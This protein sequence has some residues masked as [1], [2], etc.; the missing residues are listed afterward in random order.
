M[1]DAVFGIAAF[2]ATVITIAY[3]L[4]EYQQ[5]REFAFGGTEA[6]CTVSSSNDSRLVMNV[7]ECRSYISAI[8]D[9]NWCVE[10]IIQGTTEGLASPQSLV[11]FARCE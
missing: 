3:V 4:S 10:R 2:I 7:P 9:D 8:G 5:G 1:S 6:D 11:L